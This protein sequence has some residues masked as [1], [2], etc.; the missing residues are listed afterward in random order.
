MKN[1]FL[2]LAFTVLGLFSSTDVS[3]QALPCPHFICEL[4]PNLT[5]YTVTNT[6]G[7]TYAWTVTGGLIASGQGTNSI[8]VDWSATAPG[9]YEVEILETDVNGCDG[10][11]VL[12][13]VTIN[14]TPITGAIT[15]D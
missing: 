7:S 2:I 6:I 9:N 8:E 10:D 1:I 15:H 5:T 3:A 11:P 12:C 14:P 13:D 4:D